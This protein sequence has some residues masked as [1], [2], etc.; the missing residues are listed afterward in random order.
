MLRTF[1]N[2]K[3][4]D[5]RNSPDFRD[6]YDE[7]LAAIKV[8]RRAGDLGEFLVRDEESMNEDDDDLPTDH[9]RASASSLRRRMSGGSSVSSIRSKLSTQGSLSPLMEEDPSVGEGEED[10]SPPKRRKLSSMNSSQVSSTLGGSHSHSPIDEGSEES[11][12]AS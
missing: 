11:S 7:E 10:E 2:R 12:E 9:G 5:L 6:V 3:E 4:T 8:F 1:F